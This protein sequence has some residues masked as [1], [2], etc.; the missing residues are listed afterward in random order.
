[1]RNSIVIALVT[2]VL[3]VGLSACSKNEREPKLLH[4]DAS[5]TPDEFSIIATKPI[6]YPVSL[7]QLPTPT[8]GKSN[9]TDPT[10]VRDAKVAL[11]GRLGRSAGSASFS[12]TATILYA[13]RYG[14]DSSI[15]GLLA[16]EDLQFRRDN[17]GKLLERWFNVN[18]YSKAYQPMALDSYAEL[19]RLRALNLRTPAA[20]PKIE[21]E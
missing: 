7:A 9:R 14:V 13:S 11:G 16:A 8:P 2:S 10:P 1:M 4:F 5:A 12:D 15:R 17:D 6:E 3:V 18:V 20:P 19:I 21:Q